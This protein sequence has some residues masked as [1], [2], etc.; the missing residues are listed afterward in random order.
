[1]SATK[2]TKKRPSPPIDHEH[3]ASLRASIA[4]TFSR[5]PQDPSVCVVDGYGVRLSVDGRHLVVEDGFGPHRRTRRYARATHGLAR[6]V[7]IGATGSISLDVLRWCRGAGVQ[8]E[9]LD[10]EDQSVLVTSGT[11][12]A[13][14]SGHVRRAQA[15][16]MGTETGLAIARYL[17][18]TKLSGQ[19]QLAGGALDRPDLAESIASLAEMVDDAD[20]LE[21]IRQLEAA[22]ANLAFLAWEG[23]ELR[24]TRQDSAKVPAHWRGFSGRRSAV[25]HGTARNATDPVNALLNYSFRLV[26]AE[27]WL[28]TVA[29][30][31]LPDLGVLHADLRGRDGFICDLVEAARPIAEAHVLRLIR[32]HTFQRRD[33]GEDPR[34]VV[35]VLPPLSHRLAEAMPSYGAALAPVAER[36]RDLLASAS[37]YDV[38]TPSILTKVKHRRAAQQ[39]RPSRRTPSPAKTPAERGPGRK[40]VAPRAAVRQ[41]PKDPEPTPRLPLPVCSVCGKGLEREQDRTRRRGDYCPSCLA[42][43][44]GEIG[45]AIQATPADRRGSAATATRRS[46][47]NAEH[48]LAQQRWELEHEG[49]VFDR[50]WYMR[51]VLPGL[52][53]IGLTVIATATGMSTSAA[54][55]VRS[56]RRVPH[57]RHWFALERIAAVDVEGSTPG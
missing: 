30:G 10:G 57:P 26:E 39:R 37:P 36:I 8:V 48:R 2:A 29:L 41:R 52:Q 49:E 13:V 44:R 54:S 33:F 11:S 23:V 22:A 3:A 28:A 31:L 1:M 25:N 32:E 12:A 34:G 19:R 27:A 6:L 46:A 53:V 47:A 51:E 45:R 9:V 24:F 5:D 43:R 14:D 18:T 7:V 15:L 35:R 38:A 40:G 56:G 21:E 50:D 17:I 42:D 4:E 55:Q 16:A 20:S